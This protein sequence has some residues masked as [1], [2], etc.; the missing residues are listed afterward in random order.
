MLLAVL[1]KRAGFRLAIKDVFMNIAGGIKVVDPAIDLANYKCSALFQPRYTN[2]KRC[3][4]RRGNR[5]LRRDQTGITCKQRIREA[6]KM[7]FRKIYL[8]KFHKNLPLKENEIEIVT[9]VR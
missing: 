1:E 3:L 5:S 7:G 2:T 6:S 8:S 4:F 9:A